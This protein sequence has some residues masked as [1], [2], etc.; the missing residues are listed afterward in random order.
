MFELDTN[1]W[2]NNRTKYSWKCFLLFNFII[3]IICCFLLRNNWV[4]SF[5]KKSYVL[6]QTIVS[7]MKCMNPFCRMHYISKYS[8]IF[9]NFYG[10]CFICIFMNVRTKTKWCQRKLAIFPT[11]K[12]PRPA[13]LESTV[14]SVHCLQM[15]I[16]KILG[17]SLKRCIHFWFHNRF[18]F[19]LKIC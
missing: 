15:K 6:S 8:Y 10:L 9:T 14:F 13:A 3:K 17:I 12:D 18:Y 19:L 5:R 1:S 2:L 4:D 16:F 11:R 7:F